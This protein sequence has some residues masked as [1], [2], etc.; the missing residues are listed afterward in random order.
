MRGG[1]VNDTSSTRLLS[2]IEM[3]TTARS[4]Q[5]LGPRPRVAGDSGLQK[6]PA[7]QF[8]LTNSN[9]IADLTYGDSLKP[10]L[11]AHLNVCKAD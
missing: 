4:E 10:R 9:A 7:P 3:P 5:M 6:V 8:P 2:V 11:I 1:I